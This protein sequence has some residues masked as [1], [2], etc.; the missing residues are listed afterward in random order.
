MLPNGLDC[1]GA[2]LSPAG[3]CVVKRKHHDCLFTKTKAEMRSIV[4]IELLNALAA[5]LFIEL[6][7]V[8]EFV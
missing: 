3:E 4:I 8:E 2:W 6:T 1:C 7:T 5:G